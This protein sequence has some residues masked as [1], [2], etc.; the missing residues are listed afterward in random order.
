MFSSLAGLFTIH[1]FRDTTEPQER[2]VISSMTA[3]VKEYAAAL[4]SDDLIEV[5]SES[6]TLNIDPK[7]GEVLSET[8]QTPND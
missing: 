3:N 7:T 6:T 4:S 5:Q 1:S 2:E 8:L